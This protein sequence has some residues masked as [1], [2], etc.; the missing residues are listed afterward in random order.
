LAEYCRRYPQRAAEFRELAEAGRILVHATSSEPPPLPARLGEFRIVRLVAAGGMGEAYEAVQ[1]S[2]GPPAAVQVTPPGRISP[3]ARARCI[4]EQ[5][6]LGRLHQTHI[7][8]IH[9]AGEEGPLQYFAMQFI[10][11]AAL[12]HVVR[13]ARETSVAHGRTP[14]LGKLAGQAASE[15]KK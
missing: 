12:H 2:V 10:D 4:R 6:V 14:T 3:E 13:T 15:A 9:T 7:V 5:C 8:P 11:G 1:E